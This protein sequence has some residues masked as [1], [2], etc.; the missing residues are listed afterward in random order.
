MGNVP[1]RSATGRVASG[2]LAMWLIIA[3]SSKPN[4]ASTG[5]DSW[6]KGSIAR[7]RDPSGTE[8]RKRLCM[9]QDAPCSTTCTMLSKAA[10]AYAPVRGAEGSTDVPNWIGLG[11]KE[12]CDVR[13]ASR[14]LHAKS[15]VV[16]G[17]RHVGSHATRCSNRIAAALADS[18]QRERGGMAAWRRDAALVCAQR[19]APFRPAWRRHCGKRKE[20]KIRV[21]LS[22]LQR[23]TT[24]GEQMRRSRVGLALV[25]LGRRCEVPCS[26]SDT[27]GIVAI[28]R[29][30]GSTILCRKGVRSKPP[31]A[32][33]HADRKL[34]RVP[35]KPAESKVGRSVFRTGLPAPSFRHRRRQDAC[36]L[37]LP[38][39][40]RLSRWLPH[41]G[42]P[43]CKDDNVAR[44]AETPGRTSRH[45]CRKRNDADAYSRAIDVQGASGPKACAHAIVAPTHAFLRHASQASTLPSCSVSLHP[46]LP[47]SPNSAFNSPGKKESMP[48]QIYSGSQRWIGDTG[49]HDIEMDFPRPRILEASALGF[50]A[51]QRTSSFAA[52]SAAPVGRDSLG[53]WRNSTELGSDQ[54]FRPNLLCST[55]LIP[56]TWS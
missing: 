12:R 55:E 22:P 20:R 50:P 11:G 49:S 18:S 7:H 40:S 15:N 42:W 34:D 43:P 52:S 13:S 5:P 29:A 56:S 32:P 16:P 14:G 47:V 28:R 19:A 37:S 6:K 25:Q 21:P 46:L 51:K 4:F 45:P 44:S 35:K 31:T 24:D 27:R 23:S 17:G 1:C 53:A 54:H 38:G 39:L 41:I 26:N 30:R 33:T 48:D 9:L 10:R 2:T 36:V 3:S 8:L